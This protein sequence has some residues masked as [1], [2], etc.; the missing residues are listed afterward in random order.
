M[1]RIILGILTILVVLVSVGPALISSLTEP[2][3]ANR[4]E[5]YQTDLL[6]QA[7]ELD[8]PE[9]FDVE[10]LSTI[11]GGNTSL[12]QV[13]AQYKKTQGSVQENLGRLETQW[14]DT[15]QEALLFGETS[16]ARDQTPP[17]QKTQHQAI[18]PLQYRSVQVPSLRERFDSNRYSAMIWVSG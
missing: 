9:G 18:H 3:I 15:N 7:S 2:Q 11:L 4:L 8:P 5:L 13:T 1:R 12:E 17:F 6:L 14:R 16:V 10:D